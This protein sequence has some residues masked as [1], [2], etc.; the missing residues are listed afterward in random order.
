M[1]CR[2][3][4]DKIGNGMHEHAIHDDMVH[5]FRELTRMSGRIQKIMMMKM[6]KILSINTIPNF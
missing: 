5:Y 2:E 6:M 3:H 4:W 1:N